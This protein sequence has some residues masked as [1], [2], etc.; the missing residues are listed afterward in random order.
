MGESVKLRTRPSR[1]GKT[2]TCM[3]D[4]V[5]A[6]GHRRRESLGHANRRKAE[7]QRAQKERELRMGVVVPER[8][9]LSELLADSRERTRG[10]VRETTLTGRDEAM[11]HLIDAV[12][13]IDVQQVSH[14]HAE[15][16]IQVRLDAGNAPATVNKKVSALK[17][18]FQLAVLRGQLETN[19]F[20]HVTR[21]KAP[22][23]QVRVFTEDE[24]NRLLRAAREPYRADAPDWELLVVM[25]LCTA[26]R[27]GEL[28]NLTWADIDFDR[29]TVSVTPKQDTKHTWEWQIKDS[30]RRTLPLTREAA[31]LLQ[32]RRTARTTLHPYIFISPSRYQQIQ[33]RR[34]EGRWTLTDGRCPVNN[35]GRGF[36]NVLERA[37]IETGE[38]HDLRRTCLSRWLANGLTE[39]DVMQLAGHSDFSTTHRFYLAVRSDLVDRARAAT[40]TVMGTD[41][42]AQLAHAPISG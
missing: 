19:P 27:R 15:V 23:R 16:F 14:K 22:A 37:K 28:L 1:D 29:L 9:R 39:Y 13:D 38:F 35:F 33:Q 5:D 42:G 21:L 4:Y 18:L 20:R 12:G 34:D 6:N 17:R 41:F 7:R 8:M 10:Q 36:D 2:F 30:E 24:C 40:T 32:G 31:E 11:R 26:M 3:L 25:A